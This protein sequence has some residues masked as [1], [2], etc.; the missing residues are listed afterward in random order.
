MPDPSTFRRAALG[1]RDRV[2]PRRRLFAER[3]ACPFSTRGVLKAALAPGADG[4]TCTPASRSSSTSS[5]CWTRYSRPEQAAGRRSRP[6]WRPRARVPVPDR[7]PQRR[8]RRDLGS[9]QDATPA[10]GLPLLTIEDEWG[11]GQI[12]FT[13]APAARA[14]SADNALLIRS[15]IKQVCRRHGYHATFMA[16][17]RRCPTSSSAGGTCTSRSRRS[18]GGE[19]RVHRHD[20]GERCRRPAGVP[21][22]PAEPRRPGVGVHDAHDHRLQALPARLVRTRSRRLGLREP[23]GDAAGDRRPGGAGRRVENRSA[24]R[25][26]TPTSSGVADGL[27]P[28]GMRRQLDPGEAVARRTPAI[29]RAASSA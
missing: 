5:G 13:F 20:G 26:R 25:P 10:L 2:D 29:A 14:Q 23:R 17:S 28:A 8:D 6:R 27:G 4:Y 7:E 16:L 1:R 9:M 18:G 19:Q 21:R 15:A 22:R 11:P 24:I 12:E 3:R